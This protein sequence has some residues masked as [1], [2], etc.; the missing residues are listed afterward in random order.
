MRIIDNGA[1][2]AELPLVSLRDVHLAFGQ[3]EVLKGIDVE[4]R[5]GQAVSIIG[6]SGSGKSTIL[7]CITGLLRPQRGAIEVG[8]VRVD[9]LK[10]ES[11]LIALRKRVGFVFQQ[12]N[13]FP[14]LS[15][16]E[17]LVISPI[18]VNGQ[19]RAQ[20]QALA[21]EL[22]AK[23][24][25]D[26][27]ENAYPGELSGGQ[28]QRV[29]IARALALRPELIL[30]DEV[31]SALDPEMVGEV[32]TVIRDLVQDGLTCVLVTHEMR[33]AQEVSDAVCFTEAGR[34]VEHGPPARIFG[35][36][37]SERTRA[38]LQRASAEPPVRRA[39][40][41]PID[42]YLTFDPLRLAV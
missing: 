33:F 37:D 28:Q 11:E 22:L 12:Y 15:V 30:F 18:K 7:R 34:I 27:K 26:H 36:P 25:M 5:P 3:T 1:R 41:D 39:Q 35:R 38:F 24:R 42:A 14:H 19:P 13:L 17:N 31:T 8:G 4:V 16:L 21:R 20:A 40:A 2:A 10:T 32:L 29:A 9:A 6:P 23:V